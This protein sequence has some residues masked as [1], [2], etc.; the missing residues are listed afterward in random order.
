[1][2]TLPPELWERTQ[3]VADALLGPLERP[4]AALVRETSLLYTRDREHLAGPSARD[5]LQA[6]LRFYFARDLP[7]ITFP[8]A[9]LRAA[10]RLPAGTWRVLDLGAGFGTTSLGA[11]LYAQQT[12]AATDLAV[13]AFDF[14][15]PAL[16]GLERLSDLG[17]PMALRTFALDL[18]RFEDPLTDERYDLVLLGLVLNEMA[19]DDALALVRRARE[20]LAPGGALIIV[21]PALRDVTRRLMEL[22]DRL[23]SEGW[24]LFAPC[25]HHHGC[26]M[27]ERPR[28][29]CHEERELALPP[30]LA[31]VARAAGLRDR[32]STFAYLTI[33]EGPSLAD[34]ALAGCDGLGR[35]VVSSRLASKGKLELVG[36]GADGS[37]RKARRLRRH[38]DEANRAFGQARRGDLLCHEGADPDR[39]GPGE[40]V[41]RWSLEP[42]ADG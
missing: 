30:P 10:G 33:A 35:R 31:E 2:I 7:K 12:G 27:L 9:E 8:L 18:Q 41:T 1:M 19:P 28:D 17:L 20:R 39:I 29:W 13:D 11:S 36:C 24:P 22:R 5:V 3:A 32:K 6:R 42:P 25:P 38:E 26:P 23:A 4:L 15:A 34:V 16:E 37:L 14:S 21:E 40:R